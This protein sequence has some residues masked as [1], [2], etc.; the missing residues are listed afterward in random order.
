MQFSFWHLSAQGYDG[1]LARAVIA[2]GR[3]ARPKPA[4]GIADHRARTPLPGGAEMTPA[5][6]RE[7]R[8]GLAEANLSAM[9]VTAK[10]ERV[11]SSGGVIRHFGGMN[12]GN[13]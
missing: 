7:K 12:Q 3:A 8:A 1:H 6:P 13:A 2:Q 4:A 5:Q 10:I 9:R 11:T